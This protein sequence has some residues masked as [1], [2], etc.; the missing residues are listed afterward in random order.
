MSDANNNTILSEVAPAPAAPEKEADPVLDEVEQSALFINQAAKKFRSI[1]YNLAQRKKRAAIRVLE[2][3][4]FEPLEEVKLSGKEEQEL[5][6][7][8][9]AVMYHKG[10]VLNYAFERAGEKLK[11][12]GDTNE[13]K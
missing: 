4:L 11:K 12:E 10:K 1:G 8:C 3:V 2:A 7:L 5:F 9:Q 6:D 13:Q